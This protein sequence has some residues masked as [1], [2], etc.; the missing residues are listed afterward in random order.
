MFGMTAF[1]V[2]P[3]KNGHY[4][5]IRTYFIAIK[6]RSPQSDAQAGLAEDPPCLFVL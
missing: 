3:I 5:E 1:Q 6:F 4:I 2:P